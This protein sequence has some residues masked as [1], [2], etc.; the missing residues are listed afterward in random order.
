[1]LNSVDDTDFGYLRVVV[2]STTMTI[3]FHL[4]S[5]GGV[6]KTPDDMVTIKLADYTMA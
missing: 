6:T 2:N 5:D 3:E 4:E 1:M